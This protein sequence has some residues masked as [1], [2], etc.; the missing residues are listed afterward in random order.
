[1]PPTLSAEQIEAIVEGEHGDP[2]AVL[3][4]H[5]V[6]VRGNTAVAIR[7]FLPDAERVTVVPA[8]RSHEVK[9]MERVHP[10]GFFEAMF[11]PRRTLFAYRL[12]VSESSGHTVELHDPYRFPPTLSEYDL[13]LLREGTHLKEYEKLGAHTAKLDGVPGVIFAV[14]APNARRVSVVGDFNHWDGR[15]HPMR[16]HPGNGLWEIFIPGLGE[17]ALYKF[18]VK[19]R[20]GE[21]IA[22]KADPF[23]FAVELTPRTASIVSDLDAYRWADHAWME[24]RDR[25]NPLER[26]LAIYEVHLGSWMR[27]PEEANRFLTYR[28]LAPRLADY[29]TEMGYTHVELLPITEH[30]F[31]GSWG[32]QTIGYFAPTR[33]YGTP[34]DFMY[35]VDHLHQRGIGVILDWVPAHF[36]R[37]AHGLVYFDGT[38]LYEHADPR[39]A[40]HPDWH[41]LI[42]NYGRREVANFL[43][44]NALFWLE[45]YHV[46]GL[47]VDAV[48]SM[49]YLDYSRKPGE[50]IPN[51]RGGNENLEAIDFLKRFNELVYQHHP[52][53][54]TIA[55]ESTAWPRVSRPTYLG[56]L[57]FG[58]KWN[59]GWM[60]DMLG[61]M[62]LDPIYRS[63]HHNNLTFS[64]LYTFT[65]NF[66]LPLSHDEVVH[67]KGS[68]MDRM[69]GDPWQKFA[70]L[71]CLYTYMYGH[72]GKKL[73]FMG[74]EFGQWREWDHERSLDW[75]LL[76]EGPSHKGLQRL[77]R[78][79]NCLYR[80]QPALFEVDFDPA[81]FEWI[82]C[83]D[84]QQ[85]VVSF[86]RRARNPHDFVVLVSNFTPVPRHGYRIGVPLGGYYAE[87]LNSDAAIYG[88]S[89]LGN[90][91]GVEAELTPEHGR[92]FSLVLTLPPLATVILKR[93]GAGGP[94]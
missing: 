50:W 29:V 62:G 15:R 47:R 33:R 18:E 20:S 65:E 63:Y 16:N 27:V 11:S 64:T 45:R 55:E 28:E 37:D 36:P 39:K 60:H 4:P 10:A 13:Y 57:G 40:E 88:G 54:M 48:A 90:D 75:H 52:G 58:L 86:A 81:G 77:V 80:S 69:P 34:V 85:G 43:L 70:N 1:M 8:D 38:H 6:S 31:Y 82:D 25:R 5:L 94:I 35:F 89:N 74:G 32:Y 78:D 71:R 61:Y 9:P 42:F 14:W 72:P 68:L 17:G 76:N 87:L 24:A 22:L 93:H 30:P 23:A 7:V 92:P 91:G 26:P 79:L 73:L 2:F 12:R 56:G 59:M 67:G 46:D 41:T 66:V 83:H 53:V 84:W 3:G 21:E 44:G 19:P 49:L 51:L